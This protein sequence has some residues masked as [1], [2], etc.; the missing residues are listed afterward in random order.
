MRKFSAFAPS[1]PSFPDFPFHVF[2]PMLNVLYEDNHLLVL[3]KPIQIAT[4][5]LPKGEETLLTRAKAY[6][7]AKYHKPGNVYLGVVSRLDVP[8]SGVVVFARTSKAADRLNEQFRAHTV[9]KIYL[10]AVDGCIPP[11]GTCRDL[12]KEDER[13]RKCYITRDPTEKNRQGGAAREA[14]LHFR[15]LSFTPKGSL[16]EVRLE[17]GRKH[18]IRLQLSH[19][20]YPIKGDRKY[21]SRTVLAAGIALHA[22]S[23]TLDHPI[24]QERLT[25][26]AEPPKFWK[27]LGVQ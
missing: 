24:S 15:R 10:A 6:I 1:V 8:V 22:Q 19:L 2:P 21:G 9:E 16:V 7:A 23:L 4:M 5:G 26:T 13:H 12:I 17:T 11:E 14:V 27:D 25:F 20:G 18:Q 3:N